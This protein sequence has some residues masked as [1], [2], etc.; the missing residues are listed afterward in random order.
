MYGVG[1][2]TLDVSELPQLDETHNKAK[3]TL[4]VAFALF[5][6]TPECA[7]T[8]ENLDSFRS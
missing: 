4:L 3:F 6:N 2:Q 1:A 7:Q 8:P 5:C